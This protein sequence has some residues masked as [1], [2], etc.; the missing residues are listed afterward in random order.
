[1]A[2]S[3]HGRCERV[4]QQGR[5]DTP[6]ACATA[7]PA[8][9]RQGLLFVLPKPLPP[10]L[11]LAASA[12]GSGGAPNADL[13]AAL[14]EAAEAEAR[15]PLVTE[16]EEPGGGGWVAQDV[17]RDLPYDWS[18]LM[19]NVLDSSHV[20]FT[21]HASM[22]NRDVIGPYDLKL[23]SPLTQQGFTGMWKTGPR[24]GKLGSQS[25]Q[26]VAPGFMR[27]RL[28][29]GAFSSLTVVYAVPM[30]PGKCRLINRNII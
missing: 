10:P 24:A 4:P 9:E 13:A 22:S 26:F 21:H 23:T 3:G 19:E 14:A 29:G 17:W 20:P 25:T 6:R 28:D 12:G 16:L 15:I 27:H 5:Y 2:F 1:W 30:R 7:Y 11:R 18:T 8:A